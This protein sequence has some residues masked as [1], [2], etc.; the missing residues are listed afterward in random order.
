MPSFR[1]SNSLNHSY[2]LEQKRLSSGTDTHCIKTH[3][4]QSFNSAYFSKKATIIKLSFVLGMT[5]FSAVGCATLQ[6]LEPTAVL[7]SDIKDIL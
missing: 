2:P 5:S 7:I 4:E 3:N 6:A 1:P